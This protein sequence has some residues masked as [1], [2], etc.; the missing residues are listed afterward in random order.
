[1]V[2]RLQ[3]ILFHII[4]GCCSTS[5]WVCR[6]CYRG[7][8]YCGDRCRKRIRRQKCREYNRIHQQ[9]PEGRL[10][11]SDRQRAYMQRRDL[12]LAEATLKK[13]TDQSRKNELRDGRVGF[14][15]KTDDETTN[16]R[17]P[18]CSVCGRRGVPMNLK[19]A[20]C[21]PLSSLLCVTTWK[22]LL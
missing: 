3:I 9:S 18:R 22:T 15:Q 2:S 10:D 13:M 19:A 7:Q 11:H 8:K 17:W 14:V 4:C 12:V 20:E 16:K 5:F 1:M 21:S 6:S